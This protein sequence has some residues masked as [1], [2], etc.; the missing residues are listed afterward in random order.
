VRVAFDGDSGEAYARVPFTMEAG[1]PM[2]TLKVIGLAIVTLAIVSG[3]ARTEGRDGAY[4]GMIVCEKLKNSQFILRAPLD[5]TIN[6]KTVVAARPVFNRPGTLVVAT[7]IATGTI[8]DDGAIAF[9]STWSGG[10]SSFE[11]SYKGM[12]AD[13]TGTITGTQNWTTAT[14]KE[15]RNCSAAIVQG[16]S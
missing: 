9:N 11:G 8:A 7:E 6:G 4:S 13:R 14:G 3:A 5:I 1:M 10:G 2:R 16:G 15:T 12:I